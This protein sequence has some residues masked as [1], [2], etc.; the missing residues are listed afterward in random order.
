MTRTALC[1]LL[2]AAVTGAAPKPKGSGDSPSE[3]EGKWVITGATTLGMEQ[4]KMVGTS[5][6]IKG[7]QFTLLK[8]APGSQGLV[9][10]ESNVSPKRVQFEVRAPDGKSAD[11]KGRWIYE[12]DGDELRMAS[13]TDSDGAAPEKIDSTDHKQLVW[14]A[15]R[16]K[17]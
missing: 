13:F 4:E 12:L 17:D 7:D 1:L 6:V 15:K 8:P 14:K 5:F 3:L 2:V 16:V 11:K 9:K 10:I